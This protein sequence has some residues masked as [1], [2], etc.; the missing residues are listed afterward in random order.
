MKI[1]T[2][3]SEKSLI[4]EFVDHFKKDILKKRRKNKRISLVLTGGKSPIKLYRKLSESKIDWKK[5]D[6]F[7]GDERYVSHKSNNSNYKLVF[8]EIIK[9]IKI[10]KKNIY[11]VYTNK[12]IENSANDYSNKIKKYFRYKKISF[13]YFLLGMGKDGHIASIFPDDKKYK[14]TIIAYSVNR[15]DF[16][17]ITLNLEIINDSKKIFL[18]LNNKFKTKKYEQLKKLGSQIPV[19]NLKKRNILIYKVK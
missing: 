10:N 11:P 3:K 9:K 16:K 7:W 15:N 18:W 13:D 6:L 17:R 1:I 8:N 4:A 2:K 12:K 5:I 19:N 14:K